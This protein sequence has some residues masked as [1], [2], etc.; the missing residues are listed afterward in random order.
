MAL[1]VQGNN[2]TSDGP[3]TTIGVVYLALAPGQTR[4]FRV[5]LATYACGS[6]G[7]ID[8]AKQIRDGRHQAIARFHI[9]KGAAVE[10]VAAAVN[11][12]TA[13]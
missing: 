13:P 3:S 9:D 7:R 10:S 1:T 5:A 2:V 6:D 8:T 12:Q 11:V 4:E